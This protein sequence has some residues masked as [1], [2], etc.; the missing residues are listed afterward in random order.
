MSS[1]PPLA[2]GDILH[3][4]CGGILGRDHYTCSTVEARSADWAVVRSDTGEI[5]FAAGKD[6]LEGLR[7]YRK[8][9][10]NGAGEPC[11]DREPPTRFLFEGC[12]NG[13]HVCPGRHAGY[14]CVLACSCDC[15]VEAPAK[16]V[17]P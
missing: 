14:R 12:G 3:G 15:H 13:S 16:A 9:T 2:P 10:T 6:A 11:C 4:F 5:D 17:Q 8:P 7:E 1:N